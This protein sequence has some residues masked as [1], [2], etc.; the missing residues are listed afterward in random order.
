M[1]Q[2]SVLC[3]SLV[4]SF[5]GWSGAQAPGIHWL[6][7]LWFGEM[8]N[9]HVI[10]L[11]WLLDVLKT[12][13]TNDRREAGV[14]LGDVRPQNLLILTRILQ[15]L[16][17]VCLRTVWSQTH[18]SETSLGQALWGDLGF[19]NLLNLRLHVSLRRLGPVRP[20]S[21]QPYPHTWC[22]SQNIPV[23]PVT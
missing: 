16:S 5:L 21:T 3:F 23:L 12:A 15:T 1:S 11:T 18:T 9:N 2:G 22:F 20:P 19:Q 6:A 8:P 17:S 13:G 4:G 10:W 14:P 7:F